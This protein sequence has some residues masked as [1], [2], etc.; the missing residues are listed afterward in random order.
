MNA[1]YTA[2]VATDLYNAGYTEDGQ[3]FVAEVY[4]VYLENVEGRRFS[5]T[6][7]FRGAERLTDDEGINHFVDCREEAF[8]KA[9]RLTLRI[10][11]ALQ[12]DKGINLTYW[13]EIDPANGSDEYIA[14]GT[15][16]KRAFEERYAN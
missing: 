13:D 3:P 15:E 4:Y 8:A 6:S 5:H 7:S 2:Y 16:A 1:T 9:E 11:A 14:Q 10:N 12:T